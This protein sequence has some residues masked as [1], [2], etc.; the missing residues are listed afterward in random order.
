MQQPDSANGSSV[1]PWWY[2]YWYHGGTAEY[3]S[4]SIEEAAK[5]KEGGGAGGA[6]AGAG[7]RERDSTERVYHRRRLY[8]VPLSVPQSTTA[9]WALS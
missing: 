5:G 4:L 7:G 1:C 2:L 3:C 8:N 6:E 9:E